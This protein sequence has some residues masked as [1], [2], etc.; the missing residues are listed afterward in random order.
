MKMRNITFTT[1][2]LT[3]S[4]FALGPNTRA[5]VPLPDGG[6]RGGNTAEGT[7]ALL[8][9]TTGIYNTGIGIYSLLNLTEGNFNTGVGAG[10]LLASTADENTAT[11]AGALFSNT[12]GAFNTANGAFALFFNTDG[13]S[14]TA[15][16]IETLFSN[17]TGGQNTAG[18]ELAWLVIPTATPTQCHQTTSF[19]SLP[20]VKLLTFSCLSRSSKG[21]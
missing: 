16:G 7:N 17:T 15:V 10:T 5:V 13:S 11:G 1:I 4:C 9:H 14:N 18:G 12:T 21:L 20:S 19:S 2:M 3:L 8:S 6:Y